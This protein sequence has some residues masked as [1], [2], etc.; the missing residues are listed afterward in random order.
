MISTW[1]VKPKLWNV[2]LALG[3]LD[4]EAKLFGSP[5]TTLAQ[6][7]FHVSGVWAGESGVCF[8][9]A[10]SLCDELVK[11]G[12][13]NSTDLCFIFVHEVVATLLYLKWFDFV[14]PS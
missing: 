6:H 14:K 10:G 7:C 4:M 8:I 2:R 3:K 12:S 9:W 11:N 13:Q 5:S 1:K